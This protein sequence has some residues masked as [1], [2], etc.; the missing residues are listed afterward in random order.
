MTAWQ[1]KPCMPCMHHFWQQCFPGPFLA[2]WV[3]LVEINGTTLSKHGPSTGAG[4]CRCT[5][6]GSVVTAKTMQGQ[7]IWQPSLLLDQNRIMCSK[8]MVT[9]VQLWLLCLCLYMG[10]T[11]TGLHGVKFVL[12]NRFWL[13]KLNGPRPAAQIGPPNY[14]ARY[15]LLAYICGTEYVYLLCCWKWNN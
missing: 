15:G 13:S 7:A 4:G 11:P 9:Y 8:S 12:P 10:V 5:P 14:V 3:W 2:D 1:P 6:T